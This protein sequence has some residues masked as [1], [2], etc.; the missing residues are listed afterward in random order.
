MIKKKAKKQKKGAKKVGGGGKKDE[1]IM[2]VFYIYLEKNYNISISSLY[3][4]AA[5]IS[6]FSTVDSKEFSLGGHKRGRLRN[7]GDNDRV[8][9]RRFLDPTRSLICLRNRVIEDVINFSSQ[10]PQVVGGI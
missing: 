5:S 4:A 6:I 9:R 2:S 8:S 3:A 10:A 7:V 1:K